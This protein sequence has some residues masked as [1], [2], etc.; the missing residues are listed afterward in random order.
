MNKIR[1]SY[2]VVFRSHPPI[3]ALRHSSTHPQSNLTLVM[4]HRR[5]TLSKF[6]AYIAFSCLCQPHAKHPFLSWARKPE[7]FWDHKMS[8]ST[9]HHGCP[10]AASTSEAH[11]GLPE[12]YSYS[13]TGSLFIWYPKI[14]RLLLKS[15]T[16][17]SLFGF[18]TLLLPQSLFILATLFPP[19]YVI[20]FMIVSNSEVSRTFRKLGQFGQS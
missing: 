4:W 13:Y 1:Y 8:T 9:V 19:V 15:R 14:N 18:P 12:Q 20:A 3:L 17:F 6:N 16:G 10:S 11:D 2:K 5:K 7:L